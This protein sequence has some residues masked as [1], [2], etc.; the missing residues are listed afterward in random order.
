MD[1]DPD[2]L[3]HHAFGFLD[4]QKYAD[5]QIRSRGQNINH[6]LQ[7][8]LLSEPKSELLKKISYQNIPSFDLDPDLDPDPLLSNVNPDRHPNVMN[9]NLYNLDKRFFAILD[10]TRLIN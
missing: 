10:Q 2:P 7:K 9:P 5:P 6:I 8:L 4:L 1:P 3:D